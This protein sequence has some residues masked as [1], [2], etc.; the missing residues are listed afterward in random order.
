MALRGGA[1]F[2]VRPHFRFTPPHRTQSRG[3]G[4]CPRR[5]KKSPASASPLYIFFFSANLLWANLSPGS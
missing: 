5:S 1:A 3:A 2:P 4:G